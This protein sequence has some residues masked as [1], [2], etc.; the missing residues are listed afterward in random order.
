LAA[1]QLIGQGYETRQIAE[2]LQ[3]AVKTVDTYRT[4]IKRKLNLGNA[5]QL[6]QYAVEWM[7]T[8][9]GL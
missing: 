5:S 2:M 3:V 1:F 7:I 4:R 6:V 8:H 9:R